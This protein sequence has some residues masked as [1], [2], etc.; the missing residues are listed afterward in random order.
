MNSK[1]LER[2]GL[3]LFIFVLALSAGA[4]R[5]SG[6]QES[7]F[8]WQATNQESGQLDPADYHTGRV[9]RFADQ[10]GNVHVDIDAQEG[11]TVQ[12][13]PTEQ[14]SEAIR[15]PELVPR[16]TFRCVR[17]HVTKATYLCDVA[18]GH[19]MTLVV[20]DE[21]NSERTAVTALGGQP[22][23]DLKHALK[24]DRSLNPQL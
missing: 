5:A 3:V 10:A 6:A 19:P 7:T 2:R 17:E 11:V 18:P 4:L 1:M 9:F 23:A 16:V 14:W 21:R 24:C 13:A 12:M 15:H 8:D 20:R 22:N